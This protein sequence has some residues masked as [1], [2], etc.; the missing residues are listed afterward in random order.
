MLFMAAKA[1]LVVPSNRDESKD[2]WKF[3]RSGTQILSIR[4]FTQTESMRFFFVFQ[5]MS[6]NQI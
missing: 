2:Q 3:D 4:G 5:K 1:G 6:R